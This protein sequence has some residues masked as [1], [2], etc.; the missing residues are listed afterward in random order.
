MLGT[1]KG[2]RIPL[3]HFCST[4]CHPLHLFPGAVSAS[5]SASLSFLPSTLTAPRAHRDRHVQPLQS[6]LC[7]QL[8]LVMSGAGIGCGEGGHETGVREAQDTMQR[9]VSNSLGP[10]S[11]LSPAP[12]GL[13]PLSPL[14]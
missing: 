11:A 2:L 1:D 13:A 3:P 6:M 4:S 10:V 7:L 12:K 5:G 9:Q 14:S 8:Q